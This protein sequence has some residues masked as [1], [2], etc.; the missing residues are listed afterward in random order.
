MLNVEH[1]VDVYSVF[2]SK[3]FLVLYAFRNQAQQQQQQQAAK[4]LSALE[5][6]KFCAG[7]VSIWNQDLLSISSAAFSTLKLW[8]WA[9]M[10]DAAELSKA[11][12]HFWLKLLNLLSS[13]LDII[14]LLRMGLWIL[15][16]FDGVGGD[17]CFTGSN[18]AVC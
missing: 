9:E 7:M 12:L 18:L 16:L 1:K 5:K 15:F 13:G 8:Y 2:S 11:F 10:G 14:V 17:S 4:K 6:T 3:I